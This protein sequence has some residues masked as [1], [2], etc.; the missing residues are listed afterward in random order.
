[1]AA[2][3]NLWTDDESLFLCQREAQFFDVRWEVFRHLPSVSGRH[4]FADDVFGSP[5]GPVALT[6]CGSLEGTFSH[7]REIDLNCNG[8]HCLSRHE[9]NRRGVGGGLLDSDRRRRDGYGTGQI[10]IA[11]RPARIADREDPGDRHTCC[12]G[13]R[14][15]PRMC[16]LIRRGVG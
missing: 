11:L 5:S 1:M 4:R 2:L 13:I 6:K 14:L 10:T 8:T 15:R 3:S 9:R 12:I 16:C 7:Q